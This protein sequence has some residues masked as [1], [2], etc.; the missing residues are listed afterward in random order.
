[1]ARRGPPG[2]QCVPIRSGARLAGGIQPFAGKL[3]DFDDNVLA[4]TINGVDRDRHPTF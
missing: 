2:S 4:N 3:G 1:M